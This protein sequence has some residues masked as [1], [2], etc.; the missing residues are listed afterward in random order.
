MRYLM[1]LGRIASYIWIALFLVIVVLCCAGILC[2]GRGGVAVLLATIGLLQLAA[3][4]Y[5]WPRR[6][7]RF[8]IWSTYYRYPVRPRGARPGATL[9]SVTVSLLLIAICLTMLL[10]AYVHGSRAQRIQ[11]RR[12]TA[13]AVAQEQIET[14]RAYGYA[15]LPGLGRRSISVPAHEALRG[16]MRIRA[17]PVAGS[18][19]VKV[20]VHWPRDDRIPQGR[21]TLSTVMSAQGVGG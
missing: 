2:V 16:S 17:G 18:R 4:A 10:R 13:L 15:A 20:T 1:A 5:F 21:V 19:E 7:L 14:L 12:T 11:A 3:A 6:P 9:A 8:G